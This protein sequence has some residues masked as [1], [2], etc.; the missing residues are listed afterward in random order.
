MAKIC[1]SWPRKA[2]CGKEIVVQRP[3][4]EEHRGG[5]PIVVYV[6][7]V[8]A[9]VLVVWLGVAYARVQWDQWEVLAEQS[10]RPWVRSALQRKWLRVPMMVLM[11]AAPFA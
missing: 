8:A 11:E 2:K 10:P 1:A 3:L 6:V 5:A 9:V 4:C 7:A